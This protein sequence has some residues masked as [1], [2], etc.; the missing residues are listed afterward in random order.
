MK[1]EW[2]NLGEDG[3]RQDGAQIYH[4]HEGASQTVHLQGDA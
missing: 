2:K 1:L 3:L 4:I